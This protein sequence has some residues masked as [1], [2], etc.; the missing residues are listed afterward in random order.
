[1]FRGIELILKGRDPRDAWAL[2]P[3]HLRRLH[4]GPRRLPPCARWR[5]LSASR[6]RDNARIIRNLIAGIAV[7]PGP[8]DP[9]LSPARARLGRRRRARSRPTRPPPRR[10]PSRSR[11]GPTRA[12][13]TSGRCRT[14]SKKFVE[15]GQLGLFANGYWGHPGLQAAARG[16]PPGGGA[17]PR[18]A[19]LAARR[20][21]DARH[22]RAARTR[23]PDLPGRRDGHRRSTRTRRRA[24]NAERLTDI[25]GSSSP[26]RQEFVEQVYFPDLLAIAGFYKDWAALGGGVGNY[27]S[28]GDFPTTTS[29]DPARLYLPRG[30][31]LEPRPLARSSPIDQQADHGVRHP[32]LVRVHRRR[33]RRPAPLGGRDQA[34]VHRPAS[35]PTSSSR[36][37]R[38]TPG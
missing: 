33:R 21:P 34:E 14:G 22:P 3:A 7:R 5:T 38:S 9:L 13:P 6:S 26:T 16:Q 31:I 15:S 2:H 17:L 37:T 24:I 35:R 28:F 32:L 19:R 25:R 1:M 29:G 23:T 8:R 27:L 12:R 11:P 10:S 30:M 20:H 18:G 4:D 36:P